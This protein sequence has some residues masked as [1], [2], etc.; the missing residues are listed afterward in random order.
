MQ[1]VSPVFVMCHFTE[2][3]HAATMLLK[4][5][6]CL[7]D[8]IAK[9]STWNISNNT[10]TKVLYNLY[11]DV[12]K[13]EDS[14]DDWWVCMKL[15]NTR[16]YVRRWDFL[17]CECKRLCL[18]VFSLLVGDDNRLWMSW[19]HYKCD[20]LW[21]RDSLYLWSDKEHNE[22]CHSV[23]PGTSRHN[24]CIFLHFTNRDTNV[25]KSINFHIRCIIP[26]QLTLVGRCARYSGVMYL[27]LMLGTLV[28]LF[29]VSSTV[30][31]AALCSSES[32][33]L[34][35]EC[36]T[37]CILSPDV[38]L[39]SRFWSLWWPARNWAPVWLH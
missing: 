3:C 15:T 4:I 16:K 39:M 36:H 7:S 12:G 32:H 19:R 33:T 38:T 9:K 2:K 21:Q 30:I 23:Y 25:M 14:A 34:V 1:N 18:G 27:S 24:N 6:T 28:T 5:I 13:K 26:N 10:L 29:S 8:M 37:P 11:I 35:T 20:G 17:R 31:T 22:K